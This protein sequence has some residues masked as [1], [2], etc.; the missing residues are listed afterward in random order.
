MRPMGRAN[1]QSLLKRCPQTWALNQERWKRL[2]DEGEKIIGRVV[3]IQVE[4]KI[5]ISSPA[6][7]TL[8]GNPHS[9]VVGKHCQ[10]FK[11]LQ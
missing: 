10:F 3:V 5:N 8:P 6:I 4:G 9:V 11:V 1:A 2:D 7:R